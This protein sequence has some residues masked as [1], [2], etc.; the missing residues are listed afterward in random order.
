MVAGN[1]VRF[2]GRTDDFVS[3][4]SGHPSIDSKAFYRLNDIERE[5]YIRGIPEERLVKKPV[6]H[7]EKE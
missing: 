4:V 5:K 1:P 7:V 3:K 2:I 6:L